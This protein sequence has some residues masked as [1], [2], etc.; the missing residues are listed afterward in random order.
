MQWRESQ[1]G[2]LC[3]LG[4]TGQVDLHSSPELRALLQAKIKAQCA[5]LILDFSG[6]DYIESSGLATLVEYCRDARSFGGKLALAGLSERVRTV[7]DVV[8][9]NEILPIYPTVAEA[10]ATSSAPP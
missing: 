10:V 4:L 7:F 1:E 9:L 6:L 8:R 2:G 3:V 5:S